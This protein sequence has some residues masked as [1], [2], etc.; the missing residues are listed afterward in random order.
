MDRTDAERRQLEADDLAYL[1]HPF[2]QQAVWAEEAPLVIERG[3]GPWLF[4]LDGRKYLDGVSSLWTNV[5]GHRH[6]VL[7]AAVRDQL[8]RIAHSTLLGLAN[9]PSIQLAKR[10]VAITP[11]QLTRVFFS[12]N[13]STAAEVGVKLAYQHFQ[14]KAE[15]EPER[16]R[17]VRFRHG[18]H[19]DTIGSVSVG[20]IDL[21]HGLYKPLL[22]DAWRSESPYCYRCPLG[23]TFPECATA[24]LDDYDA[25]MERAGHTVAAVVTEPRVQGAGGM[26]TQPD[27]W[28]ERVA[29]TAHAAGAKVICDEVAVGFG[30]TGAMFASADDAIR[31]DILALAKGITGGYLPLA[32]TLATDEIYESF[33]GTPEQF[34]TF[35]HGHTY[36]GNP[37]AAAAA[38][39]TLDVFESEDTLAKLQPVI[40]HLTARLEEL[41]DHPHVGDIRQCGV[42][43]G[44]EL[45][46]DRATKA[47]W[48]YG[49]LTGARVCR[50]ARSHG[51]IIRPLGDVVVANPPLCI[52]IAEADR[53]VD[54]IAAALDDVLA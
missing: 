2:T 25:F 8:D 10:L 42:M 43:I 28:L 31:P 18:Y 26:I 50:A 38:L 39:A 30:R 32:A 45:V 15:P 44:I 37:L 35:F 23:K 5:H 24:C 27:G 34:K 51:V 6:P 9:V 1:W 19:G 48:P 29:A 16:T 47:P 21:F 11:P 17:F 49:A 4:D 14:Q 36:T 41:R 40:A 54:A 3:E 13:G 20:G 12:D 22:F 52:G 53:L 7:D 46:Q 33:L